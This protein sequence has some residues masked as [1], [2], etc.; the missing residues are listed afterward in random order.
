M[1][2]ERH[3]GVEKIFKGRTITSVVLRK[4]LLVRKEVIKIIYKLKI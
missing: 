3:S 4:N 2:I 1:M